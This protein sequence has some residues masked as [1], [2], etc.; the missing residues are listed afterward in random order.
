MADKL[1]LGRLTGEVKKAPG[2]TQDQVVRQAWYR[3]HPK[4]PNR[5]KNV[6]LRL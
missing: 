1:C 2:V 4:G 5:S 6:R 3:T